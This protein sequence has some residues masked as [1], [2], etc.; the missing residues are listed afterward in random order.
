M[1]RVS[2]L[3]ECALTA[4]ESQCLGGTRIQQIRVKIGWIFET[5]FRMT[6]YERER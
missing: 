1:R 3:M 2:S 5:G 4:A 6:R